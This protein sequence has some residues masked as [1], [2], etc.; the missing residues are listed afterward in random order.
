LHVAGALEVDVDVA[1][2]VEEEEARI[3]GECWC[4]V[5]LNERS[6]DR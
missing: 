2:V 6:V 5:V 4:L 3:V 1:V